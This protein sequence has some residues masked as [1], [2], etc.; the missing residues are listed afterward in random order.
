MLNRPRCAK[1]PSA[2]PQHTAAVFLAALTDTCARRNWNL[3]AAH[4]R[5]THIHLVIEADRTPEQIMGII[6]AHATR[7][8]DKFDGTRRPRWSRHGS[9]KHRWTQAQINTACR[10]V[11]DGQGQ[12]LTV[13]PDHLASIH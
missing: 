5:P 3:L 1:C 11:L 6:K 4:I 2:F 13:Y 9:T 12:R 7:S 10:Y 8:L